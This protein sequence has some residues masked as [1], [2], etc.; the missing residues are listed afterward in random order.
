MSN[1]YEIKI[2]RLTKF[3]RSL[4][5]GIRT[6]QLN[7]GALPRVYVKKQN[8]IQN[9][10]DLK[11]KRILVSMIYKSSPINIALQEMQ[12][13]KLNFQLIRY[14]NKDN[15]VKVHFSDLQ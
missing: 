8:I 14:N 15:F 4:I 6:Q 2:K 5:L 1:V 7:A 10:S 3:E 13:K 12:E 9:I 11:D